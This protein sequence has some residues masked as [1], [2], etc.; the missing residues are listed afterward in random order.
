MA[1]SVFRALQGLRQLSFFG[2]RV[3]N[4]VGSG[5]KASV[6]SAA[7]CSRVLILLLRPFSIE[8]VQ[9]FLIKLGSKPC[10]HMYIGNKH[11]FTKLYH[12]QTYQNYEQTPQRLQN[13][14]I[15]SHFSASKING[16]FLIFF[17]VKNI[18][19][20]DQVLQMKILKILI[21][22]KAMQDKKVVHNFK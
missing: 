13:L 16:I 10:M 1:A 6:T 17:S 3:Q 8:T 5:R 19:L 2:C 11:F 15:Q 12:R 20:G 21:F 9:D 18:R 4:P 14:Y 22:L 7:V